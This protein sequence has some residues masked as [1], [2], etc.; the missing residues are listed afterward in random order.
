MRLASRFGAK[1]FI[2]Q[3]RPLRILVK[4]NGYSPPVSG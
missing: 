4:M 3:E 2:R 1:T